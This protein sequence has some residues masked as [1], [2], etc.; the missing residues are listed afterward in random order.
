[1]TDADTDDRLREQFASLPRRST[2]DTAA[3]LQA[4]N[5]HL[6]RRRRRRAAT[7]ASLALVVVSV[8][9]G[10]VAA[11]V[12]RN[13][14]DQ[15]VVTS[16]TPPT[17]TGQPVELLSIGW[18][19]GPRIADPG[20]GNTSAIEPALRCNTCLIVRAGGKLFTAQDGRLFSFTAGEGTLRDIGAADVVFPATAG[21]VLFVSVGGLIEKR[22]LD[23]ERIDGPWTLPTGYGLTEQP[24]A[25]SNGFIITNKNAF[26][27]DL[28]WWDP[29]TGE[30]HQLGRYNQFIDAHTGANGGD[31]MAWTVCPTNDFPCSLVIS[32]LTGSRLRT[33]DPP[34]AGNGFYLGGAFSPDGTTLATTISMHPGRS[35]PDA[36]L[37]LVDVAT[38][39]TTVVAESKFGV[40]EPYGYVAW[41]PDGNTVFFTGDNGVQSFNVLTHHLTQLDFPGTYY[42]VGVVA[43]VDRR[44]QCRNTAHPWQVGPPTSDESGDGLP[45]SGT[46]TAAAAQAALSQASENYH[47]A[48]AYVRAEPGRAWN[49]KSD[50]TTEIVPETI[51]TV[52]LEL[53]S[54]NQCPEVP[55][56]LNGVPLTFLVGGR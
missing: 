4:V 40:G 50:G 6:R 1:M 22:S 31:T 56:I 20:T 2:A 53:R 21:D 23:G 17:S 33:I 36:A 29:S 7:R 49:K 13:D 34:V 44:N 3:A 47:A 43:G 12:A 10:T 54:E 41:S 14:S 8:V 42:S 25:V 5:R 45:P 35:N 38:D 32:D 15:R 37:A 46:A 51:Y 26:I 52:V 9:V 11:V 19:E 30:I 39:H 55:A 24:H 48:K 27:G 28:A 16:P 18:R